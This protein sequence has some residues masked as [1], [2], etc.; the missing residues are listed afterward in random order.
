M[1]TKQEVI[2]A[3]KLL[4]AEFGKVVAYP[5]GRI[6]DKLHVDTDQR[7]ILVHQVEELVKMK[8]LKQIG[9]PNNIETALFIKV[10]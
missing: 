1:I 7:K 9:S 5:F 6:A 3:I 4:D 10:K 2:E 8:I